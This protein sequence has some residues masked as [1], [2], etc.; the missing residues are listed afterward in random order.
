M[1]AWVIDA[2]SSWRTIDTTHGKVVATPSGT[3]VRV[4]HVKEKKA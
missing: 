4:E 1:D 2:L 3:V